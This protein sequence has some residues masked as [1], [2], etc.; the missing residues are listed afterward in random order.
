MLVTGPS[1]SGKSQMLP[2]IVGRLMKPSTIA[3]SVAVPRT[4]LIDALPGT[5][6][7]VTRQLSCVGL[8]DAFTWARTRDEISDGQQQ[9]FDIAATLADEGKVGIFDNFTNGLDRLTAKAVAWTLQRAARKSGKT[10]I[11]LTP[12]DDILEHVQPDLHVQTA[13]GANPVL[14]WRDEYLAECPLFEEFTYERG[15]LQDWAAL[16]PLHYAAGDPATVHTYHVLRHPSIKHPAAVAILSYP[17]LHSA[18]RNLATDDAYRIGGNREQAM[19]LNREVLRMSRLV[20][21]PEVRSIGLTGLLLGS[22]LQNVNARYIECTTA[23]GKYS[24]FL[25]R[26]GFR[27]VPQTAHPTE[28]ALLEFIENQR[29]QPNVLIDPEAF[30]RLHETFTVRVGRKFRKVVWQY[31]HHFVVHRRTRKGVP[32]VIPGP[33]DPRWE[34]AFAM[35]ARRAIDRPSYWII[36]PLGNDPTCS[37]GHPV[38]QSERPIADRQLP[39]SDR[40][41]SEN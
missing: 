18:A 29:I 34:E 16:K 14:E 20:V 12:H 9:R 31:Y 27:E 5:P 38:A 11:V 22:I 7:R 36:G 30:A 17:D 6:E 1:G 40:L 39:P 8:A 23:M 32:K 37:T 28:A 21:A 41:E 15:T 26:L 19:R 25:E 24:K 3:T 2:L 13:W 35:A 33:N 10:L 4:P